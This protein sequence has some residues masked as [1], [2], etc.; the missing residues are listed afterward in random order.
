MR[1]L[2][3]DDNPLVIE[4]LAIKLGLLGGFEWL[5]PVEDA[6]LM[7]ESVDRQRPDVVLLDLDMPGCDPL[8]ALG[9]LVARASPARVLIFSGHTRP[10]LVER[11]IDAGAWGFV[12]KH[13]DVETIVSSIRRVARGEFLLGPEWHELSQL[14]PRTSDGA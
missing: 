4:A 3:V 7:V 12:S 8:E 2:C 11:A 14:H 10:D 5:T 13:A 9:D 1:V 6:S